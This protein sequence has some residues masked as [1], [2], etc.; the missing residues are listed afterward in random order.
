M[1]DIESHVK[2]EGAV[3]LYSIS[4]N[5]DISSLRMTVLIGQ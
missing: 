4:I 5:R 3:Y 1:A 2:S